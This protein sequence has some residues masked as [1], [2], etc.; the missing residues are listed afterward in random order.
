MCRDTIHWFALLVF[1]GLAVAAVR[2]NEKF[3]AGLLFG[4]RQQSEP[5]WALLGRLPRFLRSFN[6]SRAGGVF[7]V[8]PF[9]DSPSFE[10]TLTY[11]VLV[12]GPYLLVIRPL[13][14]KSDPTP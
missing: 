12:C 9:E 3:V 11:L 6:L 4:Y 10:A 14:I 13:T 2:V 8:C 1:T 5:V 7:K